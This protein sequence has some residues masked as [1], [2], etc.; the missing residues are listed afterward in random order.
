MQFI[1]FVDKFNRILEIL[2]GIAV[3]VMTL[4]VFLQVIV[5]FGLTAIGWDLSVPWTEELARYLMIWV[6]FIGGA[7]ATRKGKLIAVEALVV[8][9]PALPGKLIKFVSHIVSLVFYAIIFTIGLEWAKFGLS[10]TAPVMKF[11]MVYVYSALVVSA[12]IM[13]LNTISFLLEIFIKKIDIREASVDEEVEDAL[14]EYKNKGEG[15]TQ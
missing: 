7:I 9:L 15:V 5:R 10:E 13:I 2:A 11:P 3:I 1:N 8:A 6:I 14:A 4:V 12:G